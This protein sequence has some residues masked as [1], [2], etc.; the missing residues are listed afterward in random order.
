MAEQTNTN[1]N[2][3]KKKKALNF[4]KAQSSVL[5]WWRPVPDCSHFCTF[6]SHSVQCGDNRHF[7]AEPVI[8]RVEYFPCLEYQIRSEFP[9]PIAEENHPS[10]QS[11]CSALSN[12]QL[13]K[14]WR[15][16]KIRLSASEK[17][18]WWKGKCCFC[19]WR[20][21]AEEWWGIPSRYVLL[22]VW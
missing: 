10:D 5:G 8:L 19:F 3:R 12:P 9:L 4:P 6:S 7:L 13:T 21:G 20:Q 18:G 22:C 17:W 16:V 2:K 11:F 1:S 14:C 15:I